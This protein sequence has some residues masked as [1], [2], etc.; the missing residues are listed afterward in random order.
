MNAI[1]LRGLGALGLAFALSTPV[2]AQ[3]K[4]EEQQQLF[5]AQQDLRIQLAEVRK[6]VDEIEKRV[7]DI[8]DATQND[9]GEG[10]AL[11]ASEQAWNYFESRVA[12]GN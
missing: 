3:Q 10:E 1:Y 7:D 12:D 9:R 11:T 5:A 6:D 2:L 8:S 4:E